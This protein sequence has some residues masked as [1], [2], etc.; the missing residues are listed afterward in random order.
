[1]HSVAKNIRH[2][3]EMGKTVFVIT[4]DPELILSCCTHTLKMENGTA[5]S[6]FPLDKNGR[7]KM[8]LFFMREGGEAGV[9]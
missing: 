6:A 9:S 5:T 1:M 8:L 4:H 7:C 2:L 3:N